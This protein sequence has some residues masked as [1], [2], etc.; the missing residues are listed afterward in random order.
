[1]IVP[2]PLRAA[3]VDRP[4][5]VPLM[6]TGGTSRA[7]WSIVPGG[8]NTAWLS[9]DPATGALGGT[10][11][12][13][14]IGPVSVTV[15]VEDPW[16][17]ENAAEATLALSVIPLPGP[18]Y[19]T[20]FE[21]ACPDGWTLTG[22]W[23]CGVPTTVGPSSAATGSQCLATQIAGMYRSLQ[24]WTGTT[25]TSPT[26]ALS[27]DVP[28]ALEFFA[29]ID[30]EGGNYDGFQLQVSTDGGASFSV[31]DAVTPA[32]GLT[33]GGRRAWGGHQAAL[34]WQRFEADLSA[35]QGEAIRVRLA[36]QSDASGEFPGVYVDDVLVGY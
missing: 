23:Q 7:V 18:A 32:Y 8:T 25:A 15:R 36:F 9:I 21:G 26:I 28:A 5:E 14:E 3:A 35:Y 4:Y 20:S 13:A 12:A 24:T 29:W 30:T 11:S 31:L 22:D 10:P 1:V 27:S 6:R 34:G 2:A 19:Q 17:P 33:I 16:W